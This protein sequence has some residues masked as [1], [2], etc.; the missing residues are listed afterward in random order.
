MLGQLYY[1]DF[2]GMLRKTTHSFN[3]C[4]LNTCYVV[5]MILVAGVERELLSGLFSS[6]CFEV[7]ISS[8]VG[9]QGS[10]RSKRRN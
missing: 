6:A 10:S 3:K 1:N 9:L 5:G 2:T 7:L 8:F 4:F